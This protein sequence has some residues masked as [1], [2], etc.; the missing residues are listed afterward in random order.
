MQHYVR[1]F[2]YHLVCC[3]RIQTGL[4]I[5]SDSIAVRIIRMNWKALYVPWV[6]L[7]MIWHALK[8]WLWLKRISQK[9]SR[10]DQS[11]TRV[12]ESDHINADR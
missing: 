3:I 6:R 12:L 1:I 10:V 9:N 8:K 4:I 5:S 2:W 11:Q 7:H